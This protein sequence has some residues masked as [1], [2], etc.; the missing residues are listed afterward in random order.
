MRVALMM[1]ATSLRDVDTYYLQDARDYLTSK[2]RRRAAGEG[3]FCFAVVSDTL[4]LTVAPAGMI[5]AILP[6]T[7]LTCNRLPP[8]ENRT[9]EF[10]S[11]PESTSS[12]APTAKPAC[13]ALITT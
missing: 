4:G 11:S 6:S 5:L 12:G 8:F 13:R 3:Y 2:M 10:L 7:K 9:V 1:T